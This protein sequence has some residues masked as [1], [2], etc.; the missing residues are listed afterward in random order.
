MRDPSAGSRS[1]RALTEVAS[2]VPVVGHIAAGE[3]IENCLACGDPPETW[4]PLRSQAFVG[5]GDLVALRVEGMSMRDA[6]I[7]SGDY[8]IIRCQPEVENG[9]IAAI[10]VDG[11]GTLKRWSRRG[12]Q[13]RLE[14]ANPDFPTIDLSKGKG[15]VEVFGRLV[16]VIRWFPS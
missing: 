14:G 12:S 1:W 15:T 5:S 2:G 8:A 13:I 6:G 4:L 10:T 11:E 16:G 9:E 3:P 7:L